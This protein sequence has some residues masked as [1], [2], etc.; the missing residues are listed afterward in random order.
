S[1]PAV[2]PGGLQQPQLRHADAACAEARGLRWR[3]LLAFFF[4]PWCLGLRCARLF[5]CSRAASDALAVEP[6][7]ANC[8]KP[9]GCVTRHRPRLFVP[10]VTTRADHWA[11]A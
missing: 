3:R 4:P 5:C 11:L 8:C 6:L 1:S 10:V 7:P 2:D 9:G